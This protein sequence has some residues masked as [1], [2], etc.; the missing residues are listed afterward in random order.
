MNSDFKELLKI[1]SEFHVRFMIIGGYAY[2]N[3]VEPRY[4]KDLDLWISTD[5]SNAEST[6]QALRHFGAPLADVTPDD[7]ADPNCIYHMGNAPVRVDFLMSIPGVEFQD[8]WLRRVEVITDG[9]SV[10]FISKAD[11][12]VAK[13]AAGRPQDLVDADL[14]EQAP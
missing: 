2:M 3:Y 14:L 4:T 5:R 6:F 10:P 9:F 8:A 7:F 13:R 11:L 12:I 1:L